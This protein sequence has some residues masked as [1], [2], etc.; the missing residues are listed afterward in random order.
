MKELGSHEVIV[1][2]RTG[3]GGGQADGSPSY[4]HHV[5][6]QESLQGELKGLGLRSSLSSEAV[7]FSIEAS[8]DSLRARVVLGREPGFHGGGE[9]GGLAVRPEKHIE[10]RARARCLRKAARRGSGRVRHDYPGIT[11]DIRCA[12]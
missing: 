10:D 4:A 11:K 6:T 7:S 5:S 3:F 8:E 9:N 2:A 12:L 1:E